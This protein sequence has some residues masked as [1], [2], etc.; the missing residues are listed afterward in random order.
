MNAAQLTSLKLGAALLL[1]DSLSCA[2]ATGPQFSLAQQ[3]KKAQVIVRA[4]VGTGQTVTE[5]EVNYTV[6]PLDIKETVA[7]DPASLPTRE[8]KPALYL[9][10]GLQNPTTLSNGLGSNQEAFLLLYTGKMD[11]PIV[12]AGQGFYPLSSG[13]LTGNLTGNLTEPD[14]WREAVRAARS[15]Q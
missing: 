6:Y 5:G 10:Q 13:K 3:A 1:A 7:G 14:A 9:L 15:A 11:N 4:V 2:A 8:G 12:G